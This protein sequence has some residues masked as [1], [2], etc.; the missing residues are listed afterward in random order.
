MCVYV[1]VCVCVYVCPI[2]G[3]EFFSAITPLWCGVCCVCVCVCV[4]GGVCVC[5]GWVRRVGGR[6]WVCVVG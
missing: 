6:V 5:V 3:V 2:K 1:C 4:C